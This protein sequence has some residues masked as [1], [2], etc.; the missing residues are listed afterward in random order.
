LAVDEVRADMLHLTKM[1]AGIRDLDQLRAVMSVHAASNTAVA[2]RTRNHPKREPELLEGGSLY[3]VFAGAMTARQR[4]LDVAEGS[5]GDGSKCA[6]IT[7]A[8]DLVAVQLKPTKPFQGWRYVEAARAPADLDASGPA[9]V[10][11]EMPEVMRRE[12][13]SLG[14]L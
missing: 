8:P 6:I 1:A 13:M 11:P 9:D 12:L 7:L 3:W 5:C 4:I 2:I 14:L 10:D